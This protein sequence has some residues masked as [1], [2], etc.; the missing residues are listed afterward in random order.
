MPPGAAL[1]RGFQIQVDRDGVWR[2]NS[3]MATTL[4]KADDKGRLS[5]RGARTGVKYLVTAAKG[6]W[7]VMPVPDITVPEKEAPPVESWELRAATLE[8]FYD[9]SK[10]WFA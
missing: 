3:P 4:V 6:G 8:S 9:Q 2:E 5:I 10:T 7:W 1:G